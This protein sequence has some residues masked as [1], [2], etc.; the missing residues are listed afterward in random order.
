MLVDLSHDLAYV[1]TDSRGQ[2]GHA[3]ITHRFRGHGIGMD[4]APHGEWVRLVR[5]RRP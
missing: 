3:L 2:F 1:G 5:G 4:A